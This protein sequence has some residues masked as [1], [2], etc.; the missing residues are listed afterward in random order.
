[1]SQ[2]LAA[3]RCSEPGPAPAAD[4][5][6]VA[7]GADPVQHHR[8]RGQPA[9]RV[10]RLARRLQRRRPG[11]LEQVGDLLAGGGGVGDQ[12][13]PAGA[14]VPQPGPGGFGSFGQI[15][16][17]LGDQPGDDDGVGLVAL[18]VGEVLAL[19]GPVHQ[20]GLHAD[21]PDAEF[22]SDLVEHPPPMPGWFAGDHDRGVPSRQCLGQRPLEHLAKMP[23]LRVHRSTGQHPRV[24]VGQRA[25]LLVGGQ[26]EREHSRLAGDN[27][28][29][30]RQ[31]GIAATIS[32][33]EPTTTVGHASS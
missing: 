10:Q 20:Q 8:H 14:Q 1:M 19:P 4:H 22:R 16:A 13:G 6:Q 2:D 26:I 29:Q 7:C 27:R 18:V 28:T 12:P 25:D 24:L 21:Q 32:P 5:R 33:G 31:P 15:A 3:D 17:Q 11:A 23:R 9:R 30:L